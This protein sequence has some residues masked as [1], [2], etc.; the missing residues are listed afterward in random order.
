MRDF[1]ILIILIFVVGAMYYGVEP[2][3]HHVMHPEVTPPD[4]KFSDLPQAKTDGDAAKGKELVQ[5]N[6]VACHSLKKDGMAAPMS[7]ADSVATY[8]LVP[9]D[10]SNVASIYDHNF[11]ANFIK[12][13]SGT[14]QGKADKYAMPPIPLPDEDIGHIV[15]Y[16]KTTAKK[17]MSA[18]EVTEEACVR[19]HNIKYDGVKTTTNPEAIKK[20]MGALPPDLSQMIKSAGHH[21]LEGFI[22]QPQ[23]LLHG[24]SMPRVG[25]NEESQKKVVAYL[26][27]VGDPTKEERGS[28]GI[29]IIIYMAILTVLTYL[30]KVK[31]FREVH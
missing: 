10:L 2:Y 28:L 5:A 8:G 19:C 9:P 6:C 4:Y 30:W 11:L 1:K 13:P 27:K 12:N 22:N 17:D 18:K 26:E 21:Y 3:A 7:D 23:K 14:V 16:L 15:A 31:V 29:K 20:Y 25:L 24:T